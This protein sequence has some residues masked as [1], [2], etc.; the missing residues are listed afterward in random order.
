MKKI[1]QKASAHSESLFKLGLTGF[2]LWEIRGWVIYAIYLATVWDTPNFWPS[3]II[4]T[5][6]SIV[7]YSVII[8]FV[9]KMKGRKNGK[10]RIDP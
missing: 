6:F 4:V 7:Y 3:V 5:L 10:G 9:M 8:Y 2:I 1:F